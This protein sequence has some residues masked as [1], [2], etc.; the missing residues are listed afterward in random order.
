MTAGSTPYCRSRWIR[1]SLTYYPRKR[2]FQLRVTPLGRCSALMTPG[3]SRP[4]WPCRGRVREC[5]RDVKCQPPFGLRYF[6]AARKRLGT[7]SSVEDISTALAGAIIANEEYSLGGRDRD[8]K[9]AIEICWKIY[10]IIRA[11]AAIRS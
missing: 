10:P 7:I 11:S 2:R 6:L 5:S 1:S 4:D 9:A 3:R 8:Q